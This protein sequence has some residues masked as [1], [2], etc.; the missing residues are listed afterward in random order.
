MVLPWFDV[1]TDKELIGRAR[2]ILG[3]KPKLLVDIGGKYNADVNFYEDRG[4]GEER[5][6]MKYFS[7]TLPNTA[8]ILRTT[9]DAEKRGYKVQID[10]NY[11][12]HGINV[13]IEKKNVRKLEVTVPRRIETS[14][15]SGIKIEFDVAC[16]LNDYEVILLNRLGSVFNFRKAVMPED[17][18]KYALNKRTGNETEINPFKD[19]IDGSDFGKTDKE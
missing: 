5:I 2:K 6:S 7:S 13:K 4:K 9:L 15:S 14:L 10:P 11:Q 17:T 3:D 8:T 16:E 1:R 19:F 18:L 12:G